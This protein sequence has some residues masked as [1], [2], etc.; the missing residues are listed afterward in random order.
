VTGGGEESA[1]VRVGL[2]NR[3]DTAVTAVSIEAELFG[4]RQTRILDDGIAPGQSRGVDFSFPLDAATP[5]SHAVALRLEYRSA[6]PGGAEQTL[7]QP[8]YVLLALGEN[9]PPAVKIT[10]PEARID[11][12]GRWRIGLES[13]DGA[14]HSVRLRAVLGRNLR[15]TP[16]EVLVEVPKSGRAEQELLLFRVDAPWNTAQG[17]L[18]V[19]ATEG[20]PLTR[21]SVVTAVVRVGPDPARMPRLR[22]ALLVAMILLFLAAAGFEFHRWRK[23]A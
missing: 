9:A 13:S 11:S 15:A 6:G 7:L 2:S 21:S 8:A 17:A 3:G 12:V 10:A 14:A 1:D 20:E 22:G 16:A 4:Q 23:A 19:A 5:G 18:L